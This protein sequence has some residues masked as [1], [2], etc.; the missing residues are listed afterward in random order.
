MNRILIILLLT[1]PFLGIGQISSNTTYINHRT[2]VM[3]IS[4]KTE[5]E[6]ERLIGCNF[7]DWFG[8]S[9][10]NIIRYE[11]D[12]Y[13][14][15]LN[16]YYSIMKSIITEKDFIQIRESQRNWLKSRDYTKKYIS[17]TIQKNGWWMD[18]ELPILDMYKNR[19]IELLCLFDLYIKKNKTNYKIIS[20]Y[21]KSNWYD[22]SKTKRKKSETF[23]Y[24]NGSLF[25]EGDFLGFNSIGVHKYY[26]ESG[27]LKSELNYTNGFKD[28]CSKYYYENG[29]LK[30]EQYY[31]SSLGG[32]NDNNHIL[33]Y[34][35]NGQLVDHFEP[36]VGVWKDYYE[37][38][39]LSYE[40]K[41][42]KGIRIS[43][44]CWNE[45]GNKIECE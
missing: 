41:Y 29:Q 8:Q 43:S 18:E 38:G 31:D 32:G 45:V 16:E 14:E 40:R 9:I 7:E 42:D 2:N 37:N 33:I 10:R 26:Y 21:Y 19:V 44:N 39:Q 27:Q 30:S 5:L 23:F 11:I 1:I 17:S 6:C 12:L 34:N 35:L 15:L 36:R 22:Y 28:G 13:D 25:F 20:K 24:E 3:G 4:N